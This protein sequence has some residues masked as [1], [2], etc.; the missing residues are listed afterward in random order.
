[1]FGKGES[2][3]SRDAHPHPGCRHRGKGLGIIERRGGGG[4][5]VAGGGVSR[6]DFFLVGVLSVISGGV[7]SI[8][9]FEIAHFPR[10]KVCKFRTPPPYVAAQLA[11][12]VPTRFYKVFY[13]T[14]AVYVRPM[15]RSFQGDCTHCCRH[16]LILPHLPL[17]TAVVF[18]ICLMFENKIRK[19]K[20]EA[21]H[22]RD[23][24]VGLYCSG[25]AVVHATIVCSFCFLK[26]IDAV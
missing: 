12:V 4:R 26:G 23:D 21:P 8:K 6:A 3:L 17:T 24:P 7:M 19:S 14:S 9:V 1:M 10:G 5:S 15:E 22:I 2:F 16:T 13:Q 18:T 11:G 20:I 25:T